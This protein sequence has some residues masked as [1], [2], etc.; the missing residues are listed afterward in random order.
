MGTTEI[1]LLCLGAIAY[2]VSFI[3]PAKREKLSKESLKEAEKEIKEISERVTEDAKEQIQDMVKETSDYGVEKTERAMERVCNEKI[4]A[5]NEYSDTVLEAINKNHNE[6]MFLY[7]ML[8]EKHANLKNTA[9]EVEKKAK[10]VKQTVEEVTTRVDDFV[11]MQKSVPVAKVT[12]KP[13]KTL[14]EPAVQP[15]KPVK[16]VTR[17][18][19]TKSKVKETEG[20]EL[21]LRVNGSVKTG[22]RNSNERI[23]ELH[24]EGKSNVSIA[25]ELGLGIGEVKL[26]IDLFEG[27][28]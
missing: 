2:I 10:E 7:D 21:N 15:V 27:M 24:K 18:T 20:P 11:P 5:I 19:S 9:I 4:M 17:K 1:V 22:G 6:V 13:R 23:L 26:V 14:E 12:P 3:I 25:K 16:P 28:K 8:N